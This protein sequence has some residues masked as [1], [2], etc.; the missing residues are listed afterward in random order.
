MFVAIYQ[1]RVA[2]PLSPSRK[3]NALLDILIKNA[4]VVDGTGQPAFK[5]DV[6][7]TEDR[8]VAVQ[9][10]A[11]QEAA[12][13]ID[14]QGLCLAPGFIDPHAH[15]DLPLL[16]NPFAESKIRQGVTT[17]V[18]G[19]CGFSVAPLSGAAFDE[20]ST[21]AGDLGLEIT[22]QSVGEYLTHL[23]QSGTALN[24]VPLVGHNTVRS[25]VLGYDD[26]QPTAKQ[27][28]EMERI[29]EKALEEGA[30]GLSSGL[31]YP[32]G[33]FARPKEVIDLAKIVARYDGIYVTHIRN[34]ADLVLE[35]ISEAVE[36]CEKAGV[37]VE[38][39][40]LKLEGYRNW[41]NI[42]RMVSL[43]DDI[44]TNGLPVGFDQYPYVACNTWLGA[45]MPYSAQAGG[46][47]AVGERLRDR[48]VRA[49][50]QRDLEQNPAEWENRSGIREWT[51]MLISDCPNCPE[52]QGKNV[53]EIAAA[54]GKDPLS[55]AFDL[56]VV[57][58]G[59]ATAVCFTQLEANVQLLMQHPLVA[60]GSDGSA[61]KPEGAL[62]QSNAHPRSYGTFPRVLGRYVREKGT[63]SLEEAIKKMTFLSAERF[64]L[65][66]RG[67]VRQGAY[68]DLVLF[69]AER[70]ADRATY[71]SPHLYPEGIPYVLVNGT[72]VLD[73]G[74]QSSALPGRVL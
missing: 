61:L 39:A 55:A 8:I 66:D 72:I 30:R 64:G 22:W 5:A 16:V 65:S 28:G 41:Q 42:D 12:R 73:G 57:S 71:Q 27:Q 56:I 62:A 29:V 10:D 69:D 67:V 23:R 36:V 59:L 70:V 34:E 60:F 17:E 54:L 26:I 20:M 37:Q 13:E 48:E 6:G 11:E 32:P 1:N 45:V 51:E 52:H 7:I 21:Q 68:A 14:A 74:Q 50:L 19:N 58:E 25:A 18:I 31:F 3:D 53:A 43:L 4:C 15:S 24:V 46:S 2:P 9:K 38:I 40:H 47:K 44:E 33:Y 63:L 49:A 35:A